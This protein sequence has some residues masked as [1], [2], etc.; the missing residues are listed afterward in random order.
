MSDSNNYCN[1]LMKQIIEQN[2]LLIQQNQRLIEQHEVK[3]EI[4]LQALQQNNE[5]LAQMV[6]DDD[7]QGSQYLDE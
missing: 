2:N 7:P 6:E 1:D 5:L 4:I 3:D